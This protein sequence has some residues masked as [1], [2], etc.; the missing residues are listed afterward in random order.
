[1]KPTKL[2]YFF[3]SPWPH[4]IWLIGITLLWAIMEAVG[5][6]DIFPPLSSWWNF[7][8]Y[9]FYIFHGLALGFV[10]ALFTGCFVVFSLW[11]RSER[12]NGGP[13]KIGDSVQILY[14]PHKGRTSR[15]YDVDRSCRL[16]VDLGP[17]ERR[18]VKD[19]FRGH[20]LLRL[21]PAEIGTAPADSPASPPGTS[22]D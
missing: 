7:V 11:D 16:R 15:I 6:L 14:G 1:M 20:Q 3:A 17:E 13:F 18:I 4:R 9:T 2:Q 12:K 19:R 21:E 5:F 22:R 8:R 10:M